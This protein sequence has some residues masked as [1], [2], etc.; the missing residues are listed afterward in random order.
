MSELAALGSV[1]AAIAIWRLLASRPVV[2]WLSWIPVCVLFVVASVLT[3]L[4][5]GPEFRAR[6]PAGFVLDE[7]AGMAFTL[8]FLP[9]AVQRLDRW[10]RGI[11]LFIAFLAFR[12]F[13]GSKPGIGWVE[14]RNFLGVTLWDDLAAGFLAGLLVLGLSAIRLRQRNR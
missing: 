2:A 4:R 6:D 1:L 3:E 7:V 11:L 10:S 13:D 8:L 14:E 12:F 5:A 9:P